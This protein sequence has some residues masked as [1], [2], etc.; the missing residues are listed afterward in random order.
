MIPSVL[1]Q[2]R[3]ASATV[4]PQSIP[5]WIDLL[6]SKSPSSVIPCSET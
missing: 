3:I 2:A 6:S 1:A 4:C 5:R